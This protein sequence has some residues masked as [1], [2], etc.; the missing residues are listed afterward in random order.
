[1]LPSPSVLKSL[2]DR[3]GVP[4]IRERIFGQDYAKHTAPPCEI[5]SARLRLSLVPLGFGDQFRR[6]WEDLSSP[7][8]RPDS[9]PGISTS[10]RS[11]SQSSNKSLPGGRLVLAGDPTG[12]GARVINQPVS[13]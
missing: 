11:S 6:L 7:I 12:V 2:G 4:V 13:A 5:I 10:G 8:A 1:M 9:C 3:F